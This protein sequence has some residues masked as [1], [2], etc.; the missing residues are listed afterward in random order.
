MSESSSP[1]EDS[2]LFSAPLRQTRERRELTID[3][4]HQAT[5]ISVTVLHALETGDLT[6]VEPVFFRLGLRTY[7]EYLGLDSDELASAYDA[8]I[9]VVAVPAQPAQ[10]TSAAAIATSKLSGIPTRWQV[11]GLVG[12]GLVLLLIIFSL[13]GDDSIPPTAAKPKPKYLPAGPTTSGAAET[14]AKASVTQKPAP[15]DPAPEKVR[16]TPQRDQPAATIRA[17]TP[18]QSAETPAD[19]QATS[20]A[21]TA[22]PPEPA[23]VPAADTPSTAAPTPSDP[24]GGPAV[25]ADDSPA[26]A[27][28]ATVPAEVPAAAS[29][30]L[31]TLRIE[32]VEGIDEVWVQ[33]E[34]DR[35][36]IFKKTVVAGFVS[37]TWEAR[38]Y[39]NVTSGKPHS[40]RYWFRNELLGEGGRL[41][42]ANQVL[43]FRATGEG[44]ELLGQNRRTP[45]AATAT[46][47]LR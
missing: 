28:T 11:L 47:S 44:V 30:S 43:H 25:V 45:V 12:G 7:A 27:V 18:G 19:P 36:I 33:I 8:E 42:E 1:R 20:T 34:A 26:A 15:A 14:A 3:E 16:V 40:L 24:A 23:A 32:A 29:D 5:G 9:A 2:V 39:F 13:L 10:G 46:D 21:S 6:K 41:G 35:R 37:P 4:V 17:S 22:P 31:L 38:Q